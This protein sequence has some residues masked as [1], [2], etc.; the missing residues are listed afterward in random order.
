MISV[1]PDKNPDTPTTE[2]VHVQ[3]WLPTKLPNDPYTSPSLPYPFIL[4]GR[5]DEYFTAAPGVN[6][7]GM[8]KSPMV[9]MMLFSGVMMYAMPKLQVSPPPF[10]VMTGD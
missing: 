8:L 2:I 7:L 1:I 3:P 4:Y 5:E 10:R 6:I 9:L